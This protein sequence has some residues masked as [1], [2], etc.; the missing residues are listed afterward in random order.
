MIF[1]A[2]QLRYST[3]KFIVATFPKG[4]SRVQSHLGHFDYK[5]HGYFEIP[6]NH[7]EVTILAYEQLRDNLAKYGYEPFRHTPSM[8]HHK[9]HPLAF[10][11]AVD[12]FG[13]KYFH[14]DD[15]N[16]IFLELQDK[17]SIMIDWSGNYYLGLTIDW[18]YQKGFVDISMPDDMHKSL[19]KFNTTTLPATACNI[20]MDNPNFEA[21]IPIHYNRQF[22]TT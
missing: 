6:R 2:R 20:F 15:L 21:K 3:C 9:T 14:K 11:L 7:N 8:C 17:Y 12:D 10:T 19:A 5:G 13:I 16:H 22:T 4:K 1:S 18:Q